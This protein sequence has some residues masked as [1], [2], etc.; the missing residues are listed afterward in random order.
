M[1]IIQFL[2]M[3]GLFL[4]IGMVFTYWFIPFDSISFTP[5]PTNTN[6][7]IGN[8]SENMQF[9]ENLRYPSSEIPYRIVH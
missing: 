4:V 3:V 5:V 2:G 6:F 1:K 8:F 7:S 9:Y